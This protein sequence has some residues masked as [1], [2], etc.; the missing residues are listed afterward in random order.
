MAETVVNLVKP[1]IAK[2]PVAAVR[3]ELRG[4]GQ[5]RLPRESESSTRCGASRQ[6]LTD[7]IGRQMVR[8]WDQ[9]SEEKPRRI[10]EIAE[11]PEG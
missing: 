7:T 1:A 11:K 6:E 8:Q 2:P 9:L 10:L 4:L 5:A 3:E